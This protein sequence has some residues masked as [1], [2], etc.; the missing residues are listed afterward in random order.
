MACHVTADGVKVCFEATYILCLLVAIIIALWRER[1]ANTIVRP[2]V[3]QHNREKNDGKDPLLQ[4]MRRQLWRMPLDGF[5][6][7]SGIEIFKF[8]QSKSYLDIAVLLFQ[9]TA[10]SEEDSNQQ[11]QSKVIDAGL[12]QYIQMLK[13][14]NKWPIAT[15]RLEQFHRKDELCQLRRHVSVWFPHNLVPAPWV[16]KI[17]GGVEVMVQQRLR[18]ALFVKDM[19]GCQTSKICGTCEVPLCTTVMKGEDKN[20]TSHFALWHSCQ[21]R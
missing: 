14:K 11:S 8:L 7:D 20:A 2:F 16:S 3:S 13:Q 15:G 4:K 9:Q 1:Q 5:V 18:C 19:V 17:K 12:D 6:F 10:T 21:L